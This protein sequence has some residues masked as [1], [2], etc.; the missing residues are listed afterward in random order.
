MTSASA[1]TRQQRRFNGRQERKG[2]AKP[3]KNAFRRAME[4][5]KSRSEA[6]TAAAIMGPLMMKIALMD[7]A[8]KLG[9]Y[10]SRGHGI[11]RPSYAHGRGSRGGSWTKAHQS[12]QECLRR[13][14]GG[15]ALVQA[16]TGLSKHETFALLATHGNKI[17]LQA[18]IDMVRGLMRHPRAA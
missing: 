17:R 3:Q 18:S 6:L 1:E 8:L 9:E 4:A 16:R 14:V 12:G 7:L 10:K 15:W 11:N 13:A 2:I 5:F